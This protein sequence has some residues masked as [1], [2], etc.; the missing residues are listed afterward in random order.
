MNI[1]SL[2]YTAIY[3]S[4]LIY[5]SFLVCMEYFRY[6]VTPSVTLKQTNEFA[7]PYLSTCFR[8]HEIFDLT[9]YNLKYDADPFILNVTDMEAVYLSGIALKERITVADLFQFTSPP[10]DVIDRCEIRNASTFGYSH[11]YDSDLCDDKFSVEKFII[12]TFVTR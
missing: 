10:K 11:L 8:F 1:P 3:F 9:D 2:L 12:V 5:Q 4:G 7:L 6:G